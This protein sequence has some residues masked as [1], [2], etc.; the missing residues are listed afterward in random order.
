MDIGLIIIV[1][2]WKSKKYYVYILLLTVLFTTNF[3]IYIRKSL[4]ILKRNDGAV[5]FLEIQER[6]GSIACTYLKFE[7]RESR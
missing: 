3:L 4:Y 7:C 5:G 6:R 1:R 2:N